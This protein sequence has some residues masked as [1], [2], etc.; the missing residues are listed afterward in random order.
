MPTRAQTHTQT[1]THIYIYMYVCVC[2]CIKTL[3][4]YIYI[5]QLA[6]VYI[7]SCPNIY[8]HIFFN[9]VNPE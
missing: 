5:Y 7:S 8:V 1:H 2:M 6:S 4:V 3:I 9:P